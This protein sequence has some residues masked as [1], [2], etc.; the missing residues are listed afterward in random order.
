MAVNLADV[1]PTITGGQSFGG[2]AETTAN[3]TAVG[4]VATTG[5]TPTTFSLTGGNTGAA[6]VIDNGGNIAVNDTT[7]LDFDTAPNYTLTVRV[8]DG[9]T[10]S[11]ETVT[12][13][14]SD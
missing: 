14:V 12:V 8:G 10:T 4:T 5:D 3:T 7:Q 6:F 13:N 2:V 1:A 11:T 9:T